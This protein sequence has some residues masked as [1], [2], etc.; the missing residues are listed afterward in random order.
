MKDRN[1]TPASHP[2]L[3]PGNIR[4]S[5]D[6]NLICGPSELSEALHNREARF[7]N[8]WASETKL[9]DIL[10]RES[11]EAPTAVENQF[12]LQRMGDLRGKK[13]LDIGAGL[14][15]SSVYFALQGADVT[16]VDVLRRWSKQR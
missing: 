2:S 4:S 12:I 9:G 8:T 15:E 5:L 1:A 16:T 6:K 14:G 11:F 13:L 7:H 3:S 10:V